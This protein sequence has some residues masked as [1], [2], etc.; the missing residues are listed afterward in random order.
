MAS[1]LICPK[2]LCVYAATVGFN[3]TVTLS[4]KSVCFLEP[5]IDMLECSAFLYSI[6]ILSP[7]AKDTQSCLRHCTDAKVSLL[8]HTALGTSVNATLSEQPT[9]HSATG[10]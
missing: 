3:N 9:L 6:L 2:M 5:Q 8:L 1:L 4:S 7:G 10:S